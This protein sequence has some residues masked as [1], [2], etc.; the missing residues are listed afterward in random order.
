MKDQCAMVLDYM[1]KHGS[2]TSLQAVTEL[3]IMRL[4]S[5]IHDLKEAGY[6]ISREMKTS[7]NR[8]GDKVTYGVYRLEER[9]DEQRQ[10]CILQEL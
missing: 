6:K 8:Y 1:G 2:I 4:A 3:G 7:L 10:L 9:Q 5:R